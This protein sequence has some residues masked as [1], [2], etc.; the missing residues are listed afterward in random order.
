MQQREFVQKATT[1]SSQLFFIAETTADGT[2]FG[3]YSFNQIDY[4]NQRGEI[5]VFLDLERSDVGVAAVEAGYLLLD[6]GFGYLNL[7][8]IVSDVLPEN[9][10]AIR[11]NEGLGLRLE[12]R[13]SRHIFYDAAFH[14]L[15]LF[16]MFRQD[17]YDHPTD[18]VQGIR[19][20][21]LQPR[22]TR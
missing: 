5:G 4:R 1:S 10:R 6:Y 19:A 18:I 13:L 9:D 8:K 7:A 21:L 16:A 22:H 20:S 17:F 14:D 15:L 2:P 11:F 12:A 3:V